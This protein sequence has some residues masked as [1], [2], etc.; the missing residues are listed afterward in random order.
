MLMRTNFERLSQDLT[1]LQ[2]FFNSSGDN[3]S[4]QELRRVYDIL[5]SGINDITQKPAA[6]ISG[7]SMMTA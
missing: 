7:I 6:E 2:S 5:K 4:S 3:Y 1:A